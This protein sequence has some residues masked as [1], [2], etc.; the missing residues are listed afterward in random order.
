MAYKRSYKKTWARGR[1]ATKRVR[2][3]AMRTRTLTRK[4]VGPV[5]G[6]HP[7]VVAQANPFHHGAIGVKVPDLNN[8]PSC[9]MLARNMYTLSG[10]TTTGVAGVFGTLPKYAHDISKAA[11]SP[12]PSTWQWNSLTTS[13]TFQS[14]DQYVPMYTEYGL[15]RCAAHGVRIMCGS[16]D[17]NTQGFVHI[18]LVGMPTVSSGWTLPTSLTDM[19]N[20]I[21]YKKLTV[22][23][24]AME[25][26]IFANRF[27]DETAFAYRLPQAE[28]Q[29]SADTSQWH[30]QNQWGHIVIALEGAVANT[31]VSVEAIHHYECIPKPTYNSTT[32][33]T[34]PPA[35]NDP[36]ALGE[37]QAAGAGAGGTESTVN[38][39]LQVLNEMHNQAQWVAQYLND[40]R[41]Q[42]IARAA[43]WIRENGDL[44]R[45]MYNGDPSAGF[46]LGRRVMRELNR[47]FNDRPTRIPRTG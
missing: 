13:P 3:T 23:Q 47:S 1:A 26:Y 4:R 45:R 7:F 14:L 31:T 10:S 6:L 28:H 15:V 27:L 34:T 41:F 42:D 32:N 17:T 11:G 12:T 16:N 19:R 20:Q 36:E 44:F 5:K 40:P 43:N 30:T 35:R 22:A 24:L 18:A 2:K 46:R 25:P 38:G 29:V 9:T 33:S 39:A 8:L 37:G 21:V